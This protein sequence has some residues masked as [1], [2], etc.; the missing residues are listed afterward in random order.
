MGIVVG[1]ALVIAALSTA[2]VQKKFCENFL[3]MWTKGRNGYIL[4]L[5]G[6]VMPD[7]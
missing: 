5:V 4:L 1:I 2:P 6:R 7:S 3:H